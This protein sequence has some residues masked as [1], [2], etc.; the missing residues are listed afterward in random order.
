MGHSGLFDHGSSAVLSQT[1]V[2]LGQ[3]GFQPAVNLGGVTN[4]R[5]TAAGDF[6]GDGKMDLV[7]PTWASPAQ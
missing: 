3:N 7:A 4:P 5:E 6:N 1:V 2:A